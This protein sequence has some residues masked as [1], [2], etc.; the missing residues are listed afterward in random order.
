MIDFEA[1]Q[2]FIN[3]VCCDGKI[4]NCCLKSANLFIILNLYDIKDVSNSAEQ[5]GAIIIDV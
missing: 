4:W 3:K 1:L 2:K 5:T